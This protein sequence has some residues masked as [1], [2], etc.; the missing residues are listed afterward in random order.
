M[1]TPNTEAVAQE[2]PGGGKRLSKLTLA[3]LF[4]A[5]IALAV[6]AFFLTRHKDKPSAVA[7]KTNV[8][9]PAA[10]V[11]PDVF[12]AEEQELSQITISTVGERNLQVPTETT[13]K[14]A[15]NED[16]MTPVFTPYAGRVVELTG[17]KGQMV[18]AGQP[19]MVIESPDYVAA[20][21][22]LGAAL[23]E[24]EKSN[25]ALRAAQ[26]IAERLRSLHEREAIATK[27]LQQAESDLLRVQEEVRRDEAAIAV[28][29]NKL[30]L[31][32]KDPAEVDQIQ[33]QLKEKIDR[34]VVIKAPITGTIIERKVGPGQYVKPDSPDPLFLI[35]DLSTLWVMA[36]VYE[37]VLPTIK[38][39]LPVQITTAA[40][41][42]AYFPA[43]ISYINPTVDA[44]TRTVHVRCVVP[45]EGGRLKPDMFAK[46]KIGGAGT[47]AVATVPSSAV[48]SINGAPFVLIEE[49]HAH[50]RRRA[51]TIGQEVDGTTLVES[52]IK[53]GDKVVSHG[54]L[55]L[56]N[57]IGNPPIKD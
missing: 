42:N 8:A 46:I 21:N 47:K 19:L 54:A 22:D 51:V 33:K 6:T 36:D 14:V 53:P 49:S 56:N 25:I 37:S 13:G 10:P 27:D 43:R 17:A 48:F 44:S 39:G 23:S 7:E 20:Q 4:V 18:K 57:S 31:F 32:G 30:A 3:L 41:P 52:G 35:S 9:A 34:R 40:F 45:N 5:A 38:I 50:F 2:T 16:R 11:P 12:V 15:F 55:L 26:K 1:T 24:L 29:R 28:A